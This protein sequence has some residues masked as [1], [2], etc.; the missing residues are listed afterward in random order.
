MKI[1]NL[2]RSSDSRYRGHLWFFLIAYFLVLFNY[3]LVRAAST[4]MFFEEFGAKSSPIAWLLTV[5]VLT[6]SIFIFNRLQ[7]KQTVQRVFLWV[8][9]FSTLVFGLSTFGFITHIKYA[10]YLSFIWK[11]ICVVLQ[12]HLMLAYANNFFKKEEFKAVIGPVG[13]VGSVGGIL[14]GLLT[15]YLSNVF[16]TTFVSWSALIFVIL[17]AFLFLKTPVL[18]N[19]GQDTE[20]SPMETLDTPLVKSYVFHLAMIVMLSQFVINIADFNFNLA[21]E[22]NVALSSDRTAY[23]GTV[24]TWTNFISLLLQFVVL[25]V[26]LPRV[27]ERSL[28]F[29]IPVSY[30][31]SLGGLLLSGNGTLLPLAT[32][33]IYLKA[34][35]YS[36]FSAGKELLYQTLKPE[37]KYGAKYLTDMLVYRFSKALIA[38][39]LIYLQTSHILNMMMTGFLL[40]WLILVIR[41]FG[42]HRRL[43]N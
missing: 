20:A 5:F 10:T 38:A 39:V 27:S 41:I 35:D 22:R 7:A 3:P 32:F 25:P 6:V 37:Q 21:F 29:F 43:M 33:Y 19:E 31:L 40:L 28:H 23:L 4:T 18:K 8:S 15:T 1:L 14:G 11:E 9:L 13:A 30:L 12:V 36:L 34:S 17:P 2:L 24:Y 16:G 42:I 26:I